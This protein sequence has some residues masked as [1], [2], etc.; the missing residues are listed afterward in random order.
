MKWLV[1]DCSYLCHRSF[2]TTGNLS[3]NDV[4][5]GVIFGFL[6]DIGTLTGYHD[7]DNI[8]FCFDSKKSKRQKIYKPY[9]QVRREKYEV[10]DE[11]EAKIWREMKNQINLLRTQYL[12]AMGFK[13]IFVQKGHEA[14]DLIATICRNN[15]QRDNIEV[16][17]VASDHDLYQL[18]S[19]SVKMW[20]PNKKKFYGYDNFMVQYGI[21]PE[22]WSDVK[23]YAGCSSDGVAGIAGVG[24]ATAVKYLRGEVNPKHKVYRKLVNGK[25]VYN[26]NVP[27]VKLPFK[28]TKDIELVRDEVTDEKW[29]QVCKDLGMKSLENAGLGPDARRRGINPKNQRKGFGV[30]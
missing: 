24:E 22:Q 15:T 27:L 29:K 7:T 6:R 23:A 14:D 4:K 2:H 12:P 3:F 1:L 18:L 13:N 19:P 16:V 10:M 11:D 26:R 21:E 5:V 28:G 9:K 20:D 25:D 17:I 8:A 30:A